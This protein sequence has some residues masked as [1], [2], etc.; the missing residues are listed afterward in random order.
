MSLGYG[1]ELNIKA[2][3]A[4]CIGSLSRVKILHNP[5]VSK[6]TTT[7]KSSTYQTS[8]IKNYLKYVCVSAHSNKE[9]SAWLFGVGYDFFCE[10]SDIKNI[11]DS[12]HSPRY[13]VITC[14]SCYQCYRDNMW[15]AWTEA[16]N[17]GASYNAKYFGGSNTEMV[18][19]NMLGGL[20]HDSVPD[21]VFEILNFI[22]ST[23]VDMFM[24]VFWTF[25]LVPLPIYYAS[26]KIA[27]IYYDLFWIVEEIVT[28]SGPHPR[29]VNIWGLTGYE[30]HY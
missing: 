29:M 22:P 18:S 13:S 27:C 25:Y 8:N 14:F 28:Q 17:H 10:G 9:D 24:G 30:Y 26:I 16:K 11:W 2:R 21:A 4:I 6:L 1:A 3:M 15:E 19:N 20:C 23:V 12:T 5:T 7:I